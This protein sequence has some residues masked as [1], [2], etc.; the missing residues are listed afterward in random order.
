MLEASAYQQAL[1]QK[2]VE[3]A[4]ETAIAFEGDLVTELADLFEVMEALMSASGSSW[5][6]LR[7]VQGQRRTER[8][9]FTRC[10]LLLWTEGA[11]SE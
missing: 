4:R 10:L 2:L 8:G 9:G 11:S 6:T 5:E 1:H 7:Q 3:E